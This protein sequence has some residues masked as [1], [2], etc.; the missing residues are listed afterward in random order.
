MHLRLLFGGVV[1][2]NQCYVTL[3]FQSRPRPLVFIHPFAPLFT[4]RNLA[5]RVD[6]CANSAVS[7]RCSAE[8]STLLSVG[9]S[10]DAG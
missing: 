8:Q 2:Q 4:N 5:S 10:H 1:L 7:T 6:I 9:A 3:Y